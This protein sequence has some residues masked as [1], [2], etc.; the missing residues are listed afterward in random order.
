MPSKYKKT[1]NVLLI[2]LLRKGAYI[3]TMAKFS[4]H[5]ETKKGNQLNDKHNI[6]YNKIYGI[7]LNENVK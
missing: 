4:V 6:S 7:I 2:P 1:I 3:D 5:K